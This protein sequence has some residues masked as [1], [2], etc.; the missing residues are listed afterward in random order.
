MIA[1][2]DK[3]WC[4][5]FH[6]ITLVEKESMTFCKSTKHKGSLNYSFCAEQPYMEIF[7]RLTQIQISN[8]YYYMVFMCYFLSAIKS[9]DANSVVYIIV[10]N[11]QDGRGEQ[12]GCLTNYKYQGSPKLNQ[13]KEQGDLP[14][15]QRQRNSL[16]QAI[17]LLHLCFQ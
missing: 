11:F 3:T 8:C 5:P 12:T 2:V 6:H 17:H 14:G 9:Q 10:R 4:N 15:I 16:C 13:L 1:E 7:F